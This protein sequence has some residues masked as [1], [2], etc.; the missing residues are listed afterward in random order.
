MNLP[1][2]EQLM[3]STVRIEAVNKEGQ[4]STGTGF[5]FLFS[6]LSENNVPVLVTNKHV[7][8]DA[9]MGRLVFTVS[10]EENNPKY[11]EI[12]SFEIQDF[13]KAFFPH[14]DTSVDMCIMPMQPI[15][16]DARIRYNKNLFTISLDESIIPTPEQIEKFS[17]LEDIIMIGYPI[18]LWDE[19]NNLPIIRRGTTAIHPKF[20]Y[21]N[22]T[23]V[24]LD[25]ACFPGSSGSPVCIFNQGSFTNGTGISLGNRFLLLGI[26]YAGPQQMA[27]GEVHTVTIPTSAVPITK[28]NVMINIGYA[29][30]SRRLL[31]FKIV[32][33]ELINK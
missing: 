23:D 31:D 15:L 18:G 10:T 22:K 32:L 13:E 16:E 9:K 33:E 30:K 11:G 20:N 17:T 28:T 2:S 3:H 24:V 19:A 6:I 21:N 27:F 7:I 12:F 26:L 8:K 25:I 4:L 29:I 14:P 5:F 1:I